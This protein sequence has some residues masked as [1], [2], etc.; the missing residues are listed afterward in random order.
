[1]WEGGIVGCVQ[2]KGSRKNGPAKGIVLTEGLG[3]AQKVGGNL[4]LLNE[5][6]MPWQ[7]SRDAGKKGLKVLLLQGNPFQNPED[8]GRENLEEED[9]EKLWGGKEKYV[10]PSLTVGKWPKGKHKV[11]KGGQ[12]CFFATG[13]GTLKK[14][15]QKKTK[16]K[17][18]EQ[19]RKKGVWIMSKKKDCCCVLKKRRKGPKGMKKENGV[20]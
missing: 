18:G 10:H 11:H 17:E 9:Q 2:G 13:K 15:S 7:N 3:K 16:V 14:R 6:K 4:L 12:D 1:L 5:K 20:R 19:N 8:S